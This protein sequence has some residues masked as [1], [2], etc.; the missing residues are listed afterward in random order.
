MA[1][2]SDCTGYSSR[3][4]D[5]NIPRSIVQYLESEI[6]KVESDLARNGHL[7]AINASDILVDMPSDLKSPPPKIDGGTPTRLSDTP[8]LTRMET[9]NTK[10]A[11]TD[12]IMSCDEIQAVLFSIMP[13]GP[14]ITDLISRIRM[15]LTPSANNIIDSPRHKRNLSFSSSSSDVDCKLL[16]NMPTHVIKALVTK[17]MSKVYPIYPIVHAPTLWRHVDT[18]LSTFERIPEHVSTIPPSFDFLIIY[19]M[20]AVATT[21]GSA[22]S[23]HEA[24][25]MLLSASLFEEGIQHLSEKAQIPSDLA[26]VQAVLFTLQYAAINPKLANVWMLSGVAMRSCLELGLHREP[27]DALPLDYL[28]TDLR[29]RIFWSAYCF[30]RSTCS[31]LQRPLTIP[32]ATIDA[33]F[34]SVFD[35]EHIR[36]DGIDSTG[37]KTKWHMLKWI[38]FRQLQAAMVE[39]HFQNK[40]LDTGMSWDDWLSSME[41]RLRTWYKDYGDGHELTEFSL[42]HGLMNLHRP[43]PRIPLPSSRSLIVAFES[44]CSA[45]RHLH[46]HILEGFYRRS[47]LIANHVLEN[48]TVVLF[49]LRHG[50][51]AVASRFNAQQIFEMTKLFTADFL[52]LASQGWS[53]VSHYAGTYERL[54]GPLL[55]SVFTNREPVVEAFGIAQ[56][57]E[58]ARLLYPGPAQRDKLSFGVQ[59]PGIVDWSAFDQTFTANWDDLDASEGT[60][61]GADYSGGWDLL[62]SLTEPPS[63]VTMMT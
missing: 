39:V 40:A 16:K 42:A 33:D 29:R 23:G 55:E 31:A 50:R 1:K 54:L 5:T 47:W 13:S 27:L 35:D 56:D 36:P 19:L 26:G 48:A 34:P 18:V 49:C 7:D 38:Q 46:D 11:V 58:L 17:Y 59:T 21:L 51:E 24:R 10:D 2:A 44:A 30:D 4:D 43:S 57:D 62:D 45:A 12:E 37:R 63:I 15:S 8:S 6:A 9:N 22:K 20:L 32:D 14:G 52:A 3:E 60:F 61:L 25:H 53:E 41:Q 28:T